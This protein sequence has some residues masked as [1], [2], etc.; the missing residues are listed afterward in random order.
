MDKMILVSY[1]TESHKHFLSQLGEDCRQY[2]IPYRPYNDLWFHTTD[3]YKAHRDVADQPRW[4]GY[5]IWKPYVILSTLLEHDLVIYLD[6]TS[7]IRKDPQAFIDRVS[8]VHAPQTGWVN[9]DF[10]KRDAFVY[11]KCDEEKY[12][13][14]HQVWAGSVIVRKSGQAIIE[15]WLAY[16]SDRRIVDDGPNE[17]G[18]PNLQGFNS[19]RCDQ[20]VLSILAVKYPQQIATFIDGLPFVD[21]TGAHV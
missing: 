12:W 13:Q 6:A 21:R 7:T 10:C 20:S 18:L 11:M 9:K 2:G 17:C 15:E 4:V 5:C 3:F 19:N 8:C 1:A 16:C 14:G